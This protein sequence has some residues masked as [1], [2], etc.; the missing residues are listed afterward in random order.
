MDPKKK[1][2]I[3]GKDFVLKE[4]ILLKD[5]IDVNKLLKKIPTVDNNNAEGLSYEETLKLL[6]II[7]EPVDKETDKSV[8]EK[9]DEE[10]ELKVLGDFFLRRLNLMRFGME[11]LKNTQ[12]N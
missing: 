9:I 2:N 5:R 8:I 11:Y 4:N 12:K 1:Y 6:N 7:L 10:T 3:D